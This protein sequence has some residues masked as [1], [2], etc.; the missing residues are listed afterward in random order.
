[1]VLDTG[2]FTD[3]LRAVPLREPDMSAPLVVVLAQGTARDTELSAAP[4]LPA[5]IV[6][7]DPRGALPTGWAQQADVLLTTAPGAPAPWVA[8]PPAA[9]DA[10]LDAIALCVAGSPLASVALVQVLRAG[11][12]S[13][14][15]QALLLESFAYSTLLGGV[16]FA[17]WRTSRRARPDRAGTDGSVRSERSADTMYL[18]FARAARRNALS[19][20]M[21]HALAG[22]LQL[23]VADASIAHVVLRGEGPCFCA[24]GDLDEFGMASDGA[25]AHLIRLAQS[26]CRWMEPIRRKVSVHV[27]GACV[28]AGIEIAACAGRVVADAGCV[29]RLPELGMGLVPGAG[30]T[31]SITRRIGRHR[32]AFMALTGTDVLAPVAW[33]WGLVD[34]ID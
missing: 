10:T 7:L 15:A 8:V 28:G 12:G 13:G 20:H 25:S 11:V 22:A 23:A 27:H 5:I 26:A 17:R 24:G 9:W 29:F 3:W 31:A 33:Q 18:T 32:T 2:Q 1:M 34:A 6:A 30:G 4:E 19:A 14:F 16:E 21:R